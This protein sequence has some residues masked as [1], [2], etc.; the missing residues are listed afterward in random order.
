[1]LIIYLKFRNSASAYENY[2]NARYNFLCLEKNIRQRLNSAQ[3]LNNNNSGTLV[4]DNGRD[5]SNPKIREG[6]WIRTYPFTNCKLLENVEFQ[7]PVS[8]KE[9]KTTEREIKNNVLSIQR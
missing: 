4:W 8:T 5:W 6:G 3:K 2:G 9:T 1:M 7:H